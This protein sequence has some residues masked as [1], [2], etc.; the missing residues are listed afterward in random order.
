MKIFDDQET[1]HI[2]GQLKAQVST[3]DLN[4]DRML[5]ISRFFIRQ[6]MYHFLKR[7][8]KQVKIMIKNA[9]NNQ[10]TLI[11]ALFFFEFISFEIIESDP[12]LK[13]LVVFSY[14]L[15]N[16][17]NLI[18]GL[19]ALQ[20]LKKF[21]Q[22]SHELPDHNPEK[23]ISDFDFFK[24]LNRDQ[25]LNEIQFV[26]ENLLSLIKHNS[27]YYDIA[28]QIEDLEYTLFK[29]YIDEIKHHPINIKL[30]KEESKAY[31]KSIQDYEN[32]IRLNESQLSFFK[33][34]SNKDLHFFI[35]ESVNLGLLSHKEM[36]IPA[37][38][39]KSS[40]RFYVN[41]YL[42][43]EENPL[44]L[45]EGNN[46][47]N[48]VSFYLLA[49]HE[50]IRQPLIYF[51][52]ESKS[53]I[54]L[55]D[56]FLEEQMK[57]NPFI[58]LL[59]RLYDSRHYFSHDLICFLIKSIKDQNVDLP[60]NFTNNVILNFDETISIVCDQQFQLDINSLLSVSLKNL[61]NEQYVELLQSNKFNVVFKT[62]YLEKIKLNN[63][64]DNFKEEIIKNY[65][66]KFE[67]DRMISEKK[68][69]LNSFIDCL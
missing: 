26:Y 2:W 20:N 36:T 68:Q 41:Q 60:I 46:E 35:N 54:K 27:N 17:T 32:H 63:L 52:L 23:K 8:K 3:F 6:K 42:N 37:D 11:N 18:I 38:H 12:I 66:K 53:T 24:K 33:S 39:I 43:F 55:L 14:L 67:A 45:I 51:G 7:D 28:K 1:E 9:K 64:I 13:E 15:E 40:I 47:Y 59:F 48:Q 5:F 62:D 25:D 49:L 34:N 21:N 29:K 22:S 58:S 31:Q 16:K 56:A 65:N 10:F 61:F 57:Y 50:I 69:F 4:K 44:L 30:N 19:S